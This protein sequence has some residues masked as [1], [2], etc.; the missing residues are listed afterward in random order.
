MKY[1]IKNLNQIKKIY[2]SGKV[3][4]NILNYITKYVKPGIST[5]K[6]NDICHKKII[7]DYKSYPATLGYMGY[8]KSICT[9]INNVVCHGIP[10]YNEI[11]KEG[12][13]LNIDVAVC[14]NNYYADASRMFFVGKIN[15][16]YIRLCKITYKSILNSLKYIKNGN[17][18]NLIGNSIEDYISNYNYSIVR[19]YCGHGIGVKFHEYPNILH[20]KNNF[21]IYMKTGM[22]FTIEP[23]INLGGYETYVMDDKWTVKTKDNSLSA[24]YEFTVLVTDSGYKILSS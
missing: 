15:D 16:E 7:Y 17:N 4:S 13:I 20:Y 1:L 24:Q 9:S 10:S 3:V 2:S 8:P 14:K 22:I 18:F 12:D 6:I 19:D 11:L 21:N 5:G 23:M